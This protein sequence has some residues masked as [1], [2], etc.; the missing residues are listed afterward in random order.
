MVLMLIMIFTII[1][2]ALICLG[3]S[4][5]G[6]RAFSK[7]R[8]DLVRNSFGLSSFGRSLGNGFNKIENNSV[9]IPVIMPMV[10]GILGKEISLNASIDLGINPSQAGD[11]KQG[12]GRGG[13]SSPFQA[14][15]GMNGF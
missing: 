7:A 12:F 2:F 11:N 3:Q 1:Q 13:Q 9:A 10:D 6:Y 5:A 15:G 4:L 8:Q 14:N